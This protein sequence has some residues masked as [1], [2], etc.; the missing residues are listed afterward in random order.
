MFKHRVRYNDFTDVPLYPVTKTN[1]KKVGDR[2]LKTD[3]NREMINYKQTKWVLDPRGLPGEKSH[4]LFKT[5]D[6]SDEIIDSFESVGP[7]GREK[8]RWFV[9]FRHGDNN[10]VR[11]SNR[12]YR[13]KQ[14]YRARKKD[15]S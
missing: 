3:S 2:W 5:D 15:N 4:R 8:T 10:A 12:L 11:R 13:Q 9:D 7:G 1:Y 6:S 14:A